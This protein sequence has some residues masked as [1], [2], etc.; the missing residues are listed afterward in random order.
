[1]RLVILSYRIRKIN[2]EAGALSNAL[3]V[4]S[5]SHLR[6]SFILNINPFLRTRSSDYEAS[7]ALVIITAQFFPEISV[8]LHIDDV[9]LLIHGKN[10]RLY[11]FQ[12]RLY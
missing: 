2:P 7:F 8:C 10:A 12:Q 1:M 3:M 9:H 4:S 5:N 6:P 11:R